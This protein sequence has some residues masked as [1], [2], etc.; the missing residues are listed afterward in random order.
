MF[1]KLDVEGCG[2][3]LISDAV[4]VLREMNPD[5]GNKAE[6]QRVMERASGEGGTLDITQFSD[7]IRELEGLNWR[8]CCKKVYIQHVSHLPH[9]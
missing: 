7:F 2:Q 4:V 1:E 5:L 3:I 6:V 9:P 8:K